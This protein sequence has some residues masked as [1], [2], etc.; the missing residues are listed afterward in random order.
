MDL[1]GLGD[2]DMTTNWDVPHNAQLL[3]LQYGAAGALLT[4]VLILPF[5]ASERSFADAASG[6]KVVSVLRTTLF[7]EYA[8]NVFSFFVVVAYGPPMHMQYTAYGNGSSWLY[9]YARPVVGLVFLGF[10]GIADMHPGPRFICL[11]ASVH[12]VVV[13]A[14]SAFQVGDYIRQI[15]HYD[16]PLMEG[17]TMTLYW[18]YYWRDQI[19]F[20]VSLFLVFLTSYAIIL[21][22]CCS[23]A[24]LSY[25]V[26]EGEDLDRVGMMHKAYYAVFDGK[27]KKREERR[28]RRKE[29]ERE[30]EASGLGQMESGASDSPSERKNT[31]QSEGNAKSGSAKLRSTSLRSVASGSI[32]SVSGRSRFREKQMSNTALSSR[33]LTPEEVEAGLASGDV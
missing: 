24:F 33:I 20:A 15:N 12:Q 17:Y 29:K 22:G 28:T 31:N 5:L 1:E 23:P 9:G 19:S 21:I 3:T 27:A 4:F 26:L 11:A 32:S 2:L 10:G 8:L 16:A 30:R 25:T 6:R 18:M 14:F 13:D 7:I